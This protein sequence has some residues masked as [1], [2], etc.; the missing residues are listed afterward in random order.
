MQSA[1]SIFGNMGSLVNIQLYN[2]YLNQLQPLWC[3]YICLY[4]FYW[5]IKE[6]SSINLSIITFDFYSWKILL[7][8]TFS[9]GLF[10]TCKLASI[11]KSKYLFCASSDV[12]DR[13]IFQLIVLLKPNSICLS[14]FTLSW[15]HKVTT[16]TS[17]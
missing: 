4:F 13:Y 9:K 6:I 10:A 3:Y 11:K 1:D 5:L 8:V 15:V 17:S 14:S 7:L 16:G 2:H 12:L